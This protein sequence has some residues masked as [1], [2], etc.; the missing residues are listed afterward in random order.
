MAWHHSHKK[1]KDNLETDP[2]C[3]YFGL[4]LKYLEWLYREYIK[5]AKNGSFGEELLGEI[6]FK[7]VLA[8][9]CCYGYG[10]NASF[11]GSSED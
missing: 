4:N 3:W 2:F 7:A 6:D 9:F 10:A 1:Q 8:N 11:W 5:T